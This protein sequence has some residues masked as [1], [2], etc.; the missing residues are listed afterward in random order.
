MFPNFVNF[1]MKTNAKQREKTRGELYSTIRNFDGKKFL[2]LTWVQTNILLAL[3]ALKNCF[4]RKNIL[5]PKNQVK[6]LFPKCYYI[7]ISKIVRQK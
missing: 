5:T 4:C 3:C 6:G 2:S 1:N 7:K